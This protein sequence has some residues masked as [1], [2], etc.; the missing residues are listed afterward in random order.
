MITKPRLSTAQNRAMLEMLKGLTP[1]ERRTLKD[2][3][4]ITEDEADAIVC[5]RRLREGGTPVPFET[6]LARLGIPRP[7]RR[8]SA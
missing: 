1:A 5:D 3:E 4:F 8:R 7:Q 6:V 2:P